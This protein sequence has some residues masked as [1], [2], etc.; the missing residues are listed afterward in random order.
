MSFSKMLSL[1][2]SNPIII[3]TYSVAIWHLLCGGLM[4]FPWCLISDFRF[5]N[6]V[7]IT[8]AQDWNRLSFAYL[9][10][11]LLVH[12]RQKFKSMAHSVGGRCCCLIVLS[13]HCY[14]WLWFFALMPTI[15]QYAFQ[16]HIMRLA[17]IQR[18]ITITQRRFFVLRDKVFT[19]HCSPHSVHFN[20]NIVYL[21]SFT[22][23][24]FT[25]EMMGCFSTST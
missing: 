16:S 22:G 17:L 14:K 4:D 1:L 21:H 20:R 13:L 19:V 25:F 23:E 11:C 18:Y 9:S 10:F 12:W 15:F 8:V 5:Q 7:L 6:V 24:L 2:G 3:E